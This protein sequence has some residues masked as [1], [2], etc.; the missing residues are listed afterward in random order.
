LKTTEMIM[1]VENIIHE[2]I[3]ILIISGGTNSL[4]FFNCNLFYQYK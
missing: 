1:R 3:H 2:I 4:R